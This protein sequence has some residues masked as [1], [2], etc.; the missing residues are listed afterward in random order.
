MGIYMGLYRAF[1]VSYCWFY[2]I[3]TEFMDV[4]RDMSWDVT[5]NSD[6]TIKNG[7]Y[8][9]PLGE[10]D[11]GIDGLM[12][13]VWGGWTK[14]GHRTYVCILYYIYMYWLVVWNMTFIYFYDFPFSWEWNNHPNWRSPSFF[15]GAGQPPTSICMYLF[16]VDCTFDWLETHYWRVVEIIIIPPYT[17]NTVSRHCLSTF[18][19]STQVGGDM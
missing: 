3:Y 17:T 19:V 16:G 10:R 18:Y 5:I 12:R 7:W 11:W 13:M 8:S 1:I 14:T 2:R 6:L 4:L 9:H 15:R